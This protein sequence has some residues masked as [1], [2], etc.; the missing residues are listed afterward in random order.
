M[1]NVSFYAFGKVWIR[2]KQ[3]LPTLSKMFR[4]VTIAYV[5]LF[6]LIASAN[7]E[8]SDEQSRQIVRRSNNVEYRARWWHLDFEHHSTVA[9]IYS[10]CIVTCLTLTRCVTWPSENSLEPAFS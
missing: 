10:N 3:G 1:E 5:S 9:Y 6:E 7:S 8:V 4:P 2:E